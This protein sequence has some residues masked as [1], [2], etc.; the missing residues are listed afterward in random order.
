MNITYRRPA[1]KREKLEAR[2]PM[3][4]SILR[5]AVMAEAMLGRW[6]DQWRYDIGYQ[7]VHR[8]TQKSQPLELEIHT[9]AAD[10]HHGCWDS[11]ARHI[12]LDSSG[13]QGKRSA[14]L[15][16][17]A[18][19]AWPLVR[20]WEQRRQ[21][22]RDNWSVDLHTHGKA[23]NYTYEKMLALVL[24][25]TVWEDCWYRW[26]IRRKNRSLKNS[27]AGPDDRRWTSTDKY[28]NTCQKV[29]V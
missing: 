13:T 14:L 23:W 19:E 6:G 17:W 11:W 29:I 22:R 24:H 18:G 25:V 12:L 27:C 10:E 1:V 5:M 2:N 8:G 4:R 15:P 7:K 28:L 3:G 21:H 9:A 20:Q 26:N 16:S